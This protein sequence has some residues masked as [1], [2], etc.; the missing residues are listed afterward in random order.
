MESQNT[1]NSQNKLEKEE[2]S[3]RYLLPD[4]KLY[5]KTT[6]IKQYGIGTKTD[7][8]INGTEQRAQE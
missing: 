7:T 3:Q 1:P 5:Y 6:I 8:Q 2:Q 4:F